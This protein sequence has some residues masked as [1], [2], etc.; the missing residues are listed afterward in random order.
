MNPEV[1]GRLTGTP[2]CAVPC[3][4]YRTVLYY[5]PVQY[6]TSTVV[7]LYS[8]VLYSTVYTVLYSTVQYSI[9]RVYSTVQYCT[10]AYAR[11][12]TV[13]YCT[14][15]GTICGLY[16]KETLASEWVYYPL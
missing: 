13:L 8:T 4:L 10:D 15:T 6:S 1:E 3:V 7:L 12:S 5:I 9:L 16:I 14:S 11:Y 2:D